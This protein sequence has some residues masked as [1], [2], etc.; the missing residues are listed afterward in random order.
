MLRKPLIFN[1]DCVRCNARV[2]SKPVT[3]EGGIIAAAVN[4]IVFHVG[5]NLVHVIGDNHGPDGDIIH[6]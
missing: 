2:R 5:F 6:G 4:G 3:L 1:V